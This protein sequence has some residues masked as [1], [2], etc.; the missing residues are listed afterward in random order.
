MMRVHKG[1]IQK[2]LTKIILFVTS[3]SFL[4]GYLFFTMLYFQNREK[5]SLILAKTIE[6]V[7][8]QDLAKLVFLNN[9]ATSADITTKLH[10]FP[11]LESVVVYKNSKN[12]IYQYN[13]DDKSFSATKECTPQ[14]PK[15]LNNILII[16][17]DVNYLGQK[18]ACVEMRLARESFLSIVEKDIWK[19]VLVYLFIVFF[20]FLLAHFYAKLFIKPILT[21]VKFLE[22]IEET[23]ALDKRIELVGDDEFTIL[24]DETNSM[25]ENLENSLKLKALAEKKVN[26]L[27]RYDSLTGLAN[28]ELFLQALQSKV[29]NLSVKKWHL[30]FCVD[31]ENFKMLNDVHGHEIGDLVLQA[32]AQKL[33]EKFNDNTIIAKIG[34]D[35]FL[36]CYRDVDNTKEK[37]V[38]KAENIIDKLKKIS[39]E[40]FTIK[41]QK[42]YL[43]LHVGINVYS[44]DIKN[45]TVILKETDSALQN[46][47]SKEKMVSFYNKSLDMK[48]KERL[49]MYAKLATAI[50][51]KQFVLYYQLQNR[52][53]GSI[54]GAESLIRW[55][56]PTEGMIYPD[57]FIGI[58]EN[59][60]LIV[61][62][63][64]WVLDEGCRQL[65]LWQKSAKT[66][67]WVLAIN[68]SAKQFNQD[69][70]LEIVKTTIEKYNIVTKN[71]KIE[72]TESLLS[73]NLE[74]MIEKMQA[75]RDLDIQI[76]ID[77]FGTG[78]SSLQY[79]KKLPV[80]QIKIDQNFIFGM[81]G[82]KTDIGIIK[83][84]ID[85]G[86]V[87]DFDVI[88][89]GVETKEHFEL[90]KKMHCHYF[91]GYYFARPEPIETVD[92]IIESL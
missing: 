56:H 11:T 84:I 81:L 9:L 20:S 34:I 85:L 19:I 2:R 74:K 68:V 35:E 23:S 18:I 60:G 52:D 28:K 7:I 6:S 76:S 48:A 21:L 72:L 4:I 42:L 25:L 55:K 89:E 32:L 71:L 15:V 51:E 10:S 88:A 70:F 27:R 92:A 73:N 75:L 91:Q 69:D 14:K 63:G 40:V 77:D 45:A 1:S 79:L 54:Y 58:A 47:K 8:A 65:S 61:D 24:Y 13:K 67:E 82:N 22:D 16:R 78:Y 80:N 30:M 64:T 62:I 50:K 39:S 36:I 17:D 59:T 43:S 53:D 86:E 49:G 3:A 31:I 26:Y 38:Q 46:A 66:K 33:Q 5:D 29:D 44:D 12:A 83:A 90:L 57:Q 37:A 87:F 41:N